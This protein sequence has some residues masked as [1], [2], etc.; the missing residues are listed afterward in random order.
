VRWLCSSVRFFFCYL[1]ITWLTCNR[2]HVKCRARAAGTPL[3]GQRSSIPFATDCCLA[4]IQRQASSN[5]TLHR[6]GCIL[7]SQNFSFPFWPISSF[8]YIREGVFNLRIRLDSDVL[9]K[10][11]P[12]IYTLPRAYTQFLPDA[13]LIMDRLRLIQR[14]IF[15]MTRMHSLRWKCQVGNQLDV[16]NY[17]V[18]VRDNIQLRVDWGFYIGVTIGLFLHWW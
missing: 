4:F 17:M 9:R 3:D 7:F 16:F 8:G 5:T 13:V 11:T 1:S 12:T 6:L 15:P 18:E 2:T 10:C 14:K